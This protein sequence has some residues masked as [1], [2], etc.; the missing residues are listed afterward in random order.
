MLQE[1]GIAGLFQ[2]AL[3][4]P[5]QKAVRRKKF[6]GDCALQPQVYGSVDDTHPTLTKLCVHPVVRDDGANHRCFVFVLVYAASLRSCEVFGSKI[7]TGRNAR[8][9][10]FK[11]SHPRGSFTR[12]EAANTS[13]SRR[14][15][16]TWR[17]AYPSMRNWCAS[18]YY[19]PSTS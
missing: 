10:F 9:T 13:S 7:D 8:A 2:K 15:P 5:F 19:Q 17:K 16:F 1:R 18:D 11:A 12:A 6:E 14:P 3:L 4:V